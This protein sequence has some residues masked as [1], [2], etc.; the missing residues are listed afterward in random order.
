METTLT[1]F[2]RQLTL[3]ATVV[4]NETIKDIVNFVRS[5]MCI[6]STVG[7]KTLSWDG[8]VAQLD[9]LEEMYGKLDHT[10]ET[11]YFLTIENEDIFNTGT[12]M[13]NNSILYFMPP[14]KYRNILMSV[15]FTVCNSSIVSVVMGI[16]ASLQYWYSGKSRLPRLSIL[17]WLFAGHVMHK[18]NKTRLVKCKYLLSAPITVMR[19]MLLSEFDVDSLWIADNTWI[20][21][22]IKLQPSLYSG[23]LEEIQTHLSP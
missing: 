20:D 12:E 19:N 1:Y 2:N 10:N 14:R 13:L 5:Q 23:T 7:E 3:V 11:M 6:K 9:Q 4:D 16:T 17:L 22:Y 21:E 8:L 18:L 15:I